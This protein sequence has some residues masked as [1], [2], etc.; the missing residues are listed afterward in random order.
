M[1]NSAFLR[2]LNIISLRE[3]NINGKGIKIAIID[4]GGNSFD[5]N[6]V[7]KGGYN[8]ID[9]SNNY[10]DDDGHGTSVTSIISSVAP[11][12]DIYSV[13]ADLSVSNDIVI[14]Q[15]VE[16]LR[17]CIVNKMDI[18]NMSFGFNGYESNELEDLCTEAKKKGIMLICAAGNNSINA[19]LAI[20]ASYDSTLAISNV[21]KNNVISNT[22]SY[23]FGMDF[24]CYGEGLI[25]LDKS[26]KNTT[27]SGTSFSSALA[28]GIIALL[29]QQNPNLTCREIY[30]ILKDN[31]IE[32]GDKGKDLY[33][34][35]GLIQA[36]IVSADYKKEYQLI[37]EDMQ[38]NIYFPQIKLEVQ[39][40]NKINSNIVF[41]PDEMDYVKFKTTDESI[42]TV[43]QE[44]I[45]TG[46]K[47]GTTNLIA[48]YNNRAA[49]CEIVVSEFIPVE[50]EPDI[51]TTN[52]FN[53]QELNIYK[54]HEAGIKGK[55]IKIAY[56]GYGCISTSKV[57]VKTYKDIT[58]ENL[59][60]ADT[61]GFGTIYTSL[62]SGALTGIAPECEMYVLKDAIG[63][64][65]RSYKNCKI[66]VE[67]CITNKIDIIYVEGLDPN[68]SES[69]LKK[70]YN[71]N[72]ICV[73]SAGGWKLNSEQ[74]SIYSLTVSYVTPQKQFIGG[75]VNNKTP[76]TGDFIDCVSY[77]YGVTCVNSKGK[78]DIYELGMQPHNTF[79]CRVAAMQ[80]M[81][82]CALLKQQDSTIN[83][84]VKIRNLLPKLCEPLYGGK[85]NNTGYGLLKADILK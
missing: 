46:K 43:N 78:Y 32:L 35:Y 72:I 61:N 29:K 38:K 16:G 22:S 60:F 71:A 8:C 7:I 57:N 17:W 49:V 10:S 34:G 66:A 31:C 83:N 73:S 42:A 68:V 21:D 18:V 9:K 53:L 23:S 64:A 12:S 37:L 81:G 13:K 24:C 6:L 76:F 65:I 54:L 45:V 36:S 51:S 2:A 14:K 26:G 40:S 3:K 69:V 50:V 56:L 70:C 5:G 1:D 74:T 84:V 79:L 67:W 85:N 30:E 33:Y 39:V 47:I 58:V 11:E 82:I 63:Y 52:L 80:V 48:I 27:V 19:Y 4:T 62:I 44:G 41:L 55:G 25:A 20:P 59:S 77:G 15:V 75:D 28:S